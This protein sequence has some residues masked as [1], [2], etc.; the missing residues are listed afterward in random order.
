MTPAELNTAVGV[1]VA[2]I[3]FVTWATVLV[4]DPHRHPVGAPVMVLLA[5]GMLLV[6]GLSLQHEMWAVGVFAAA[7]RAIVAGAGVR[8]LWHVLRSARVVR[9]EP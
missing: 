4:L 5:F 7:N 2:A 1:I 9:H 6:S 3:G 8:A